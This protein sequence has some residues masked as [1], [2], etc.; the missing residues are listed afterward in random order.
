MGSISRCDRDTHERGATRGATPQ[1]ACAFGHHTTEIIGICGQFRV[2]HSGVRAGGRAS[3]D[4]RMNLEDNRRSPRRHALRTRAPWFAAVLG[5]SV[6]CAEGT[7]RYEDRD[8][9]GG[10]ITGNGDAFDTGTVS[11]SDNWP[12]FEPYDIA[13]AGWTFETVATEP[14]AVRGDATLAFTQGG[15]AEVAWSELDPSDNGVG[16]RNIWLASR[17]VTEWSADMHTDDDGTLYFA[18][19]LAADDEVLHLAYHG[20]PDTTRDVYFAERTIAGW[21]ETNLSSNVDG[22]DPRACGDPEVLAHPDAGPHVA[23]IS[24]PASDSGSRDGPYEVRVVDA[25]NPST[26]DVRHTINP[27]D[28]HPL[29][30]EEFAAAV[31]PDGDL[32]VV[33]SCRPDEVL[34]ASNASGAWQE[35]TLALGGD[36]RAETPALAFDHA[37]ETLHI[38]YMRRHACSDDDSGCSTIYHRRLDVATESLS[39]DTEVS[40][41][42]DRAAR[43]PA[44]TVDPQSRVLIA[45]ESDG[46]GGSSDPDSDI[47]LAWSDDDGGSFAPRVTISP[48]RDSGVTDSRPTAFQLHPQTG[49]P[50]LA[51]QTNHYLGDGGLA[52]DI[53]HGYLEPR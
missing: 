41:A 51:I 6:A 48:D 52:V 15:I 53:A 26:P 22:S 46:R 4:A 31:G 38:A 27:P 50:H 43:R 10:I 20:S 9:G 11:G 45:Y 39:S 13:E 34:Y 33:A 30:C 40:D 47:R 28:D 32:H 5:L 3:Y 1:R 16:S 24:A 18:P 29:G 42:P 44:V 35:S 36:S 12:D 17:V 14:E 2:A 7:S 8:A 21:T 25:S 19:N 37:G 49:L 23:Y